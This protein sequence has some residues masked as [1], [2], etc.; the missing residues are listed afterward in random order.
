MHSTSPPSLG[1]RREALTEDQ[2]YLQKLLSRLNGPVTASGPD[3][4]A[5]NER[6]RWADMAQ[7][8]P[9]AVSHVAVQSIDP[10]TLAYGMHDSPAALAA[11]IVER[12]YNWSDH[13]PGDFEAS[14]SRRSVLD[15]LSIYWFTETFVT[16][17]R[18]YW[19]DL[20]QPWTP[21]HNRTPVI[22][23]PVGISVFPV[24]VVYR[25][26]KIAEENA[27][28]V[29]WHDMPRGGHFAWAEV[30]EVLVDEVRKFFR[31]LR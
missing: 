14:F 20:R 30:P 5:P 27:N 24:D 11:W 16:S 2:T 12:R 23:V 29:Y 9:T 31:P 21:S 28:I 25:P 26:R 4:F 22:D 6:H 3:D 13:A 18:M 19:H 8:W 1:S 7:R 10:Q 15:L 17:A